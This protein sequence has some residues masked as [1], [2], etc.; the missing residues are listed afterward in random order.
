MWPTCLP[1]CRE[2]Y[3]DGQETPVM[4]PPAVAV[5][6][7]TLSVHRGNNCWVRLAGSSSLGLTQYTHRLGAAKHLFGFDRG[8][9]WIL[10]RYIYFLL[11]RTYLLHK[12]NELHRPCST[13]VL[14]PAAWDSCILIIPNQTIHPPKHL[15]MYLLA[16]LSLAM[17]ILGDRSRDFGYTGTP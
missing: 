5:G 14:A 1:L 9:L 7:E 15:V 2:G 6:Q 11:I 10:I 13:Q 8:I 12:M 3:S 17:A 16:W 4:L